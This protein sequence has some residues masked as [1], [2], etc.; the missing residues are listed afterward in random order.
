M[1]TSVGGG[2]GSGGN[3][4]VDQRFVVLDRSVIAANAVGG[5]GGNVLI[6]AGQF[7]PSAGSAVTATSQLGVSGE[8]AIVGPP[9]NL[10]GSLVVLASELRAAAALLREGCAVRGGGAPR[11][12]LVAAG[13]GGRRQGL[14]TTVPALYFAN[15]PVRGG[16]DEPPRAAAD[17]PQRTAVTLSARCG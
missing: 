10:N 3:I 4:T 17:P 15:R 13:R 8:I 12:S 7:V 2:S 6:R 1:T 14:E 9:L 16:R 11:S 5:N